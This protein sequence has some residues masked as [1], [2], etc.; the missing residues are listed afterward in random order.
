MSDRN[1]GTTCPHCGTETGIP[2]GAP[3][4][5]PVDLTYEELATLTR[6]EWRKRLGPQSYV[7][8]HRAQ[9]IKTLAALARDPD[10]TELADDLDRGLSLIIAELRMEGAGWGAVRHEA[11]KLIHAL[12]RVFRGAGANSVTTEAFVEPARAALDRL[13]ALP[14]PPAQG[15]SFSLAG[16]D[17]QEVEA[18]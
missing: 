6:S 1:L 3:D 13:L 8:T 10:S 14:S 17:R 16:A 12:R 11:A 7:R 5:L 2:R 4:D 15:T 18:E 9:V